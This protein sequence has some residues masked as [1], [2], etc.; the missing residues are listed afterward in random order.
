[1]CHRTLKHTL[2]QGR[3][4]QL[5]FFL[6][7]SSGTHSTYIFPQP[8]SYPYSPRFR[9]STCASSLSLV[10]YRLASFPY[11]NWGT[12]FVCPLTDWGLQILSLL[13]SSPINAHFFHFY[14][15]SRPYRCLL[16][17]VNWPNTACLKLWKPM[18]LSPSGLPLLFLFNPVVLCY[19]QSFDNTRQIGHAL[20]DQ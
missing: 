2:E 5:N 1:M 9:L 12:Y 7:L 8:P 14:S 16:I 4:A 10:D 6:F 18:F 11:I 13:E 3:R 15:G 20:I 19:S 17:A